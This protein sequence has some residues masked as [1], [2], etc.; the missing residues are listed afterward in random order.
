MAKGASKRVIPVA[1]LGTETKGI[2]FPLAGLQAI[3]LRETIDLKQ[4]FDDCSS[5]LHQ[6][7]TDLDWDKYFQEFNHI[8]HEILQ[9]K[10]YGPEESNHQIQTFDALSNEFLGILQN[11][12]NES[13]TSIITKIQVVVGKMLALIPSIPR[14]DKSR[15]DQVLSS[16]QLNPDILECFPDSKAQLAKILTIIGPFVDR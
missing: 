12:G 5:F 2:S 10:S 16:F 11:I 15:I 8:Q 4:V 9:S 7:C 14:R 6:Q 13:G 1:F 3:M